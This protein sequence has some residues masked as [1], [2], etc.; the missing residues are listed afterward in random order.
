MYSTKNSQAGLV[1]ILVTMVMMIVIS[2]IVLGFAEISTNEQRNSLDSQLSVQAYYAAESGVDDAQAAIS[3]ILTSG[4]IVPNKTVCGNQPGYTLPGTVNATNNVS[5][6]CVLVN[7]SP[8]SLVY[9]VGFTSTVVPLISNGPSF[10]GISFSWKIPQGVVGNVSSCF[11]N[12]ASLGTFPVASGAGQWTCVYPVVRVDFL[13]ANGVLA[14]AN[15]NADTAT[16]FF[17][18][19]NSLSVNNNT[20]LA[21]RG[22]LVPARCTNSSC[23]ANLSS[24]LGGTKYYA[25]ITTLYRTNSVLTITANGNKPFSNAQAT[26]DATGRAQ[27]VLKRVQVAV[28]LSDAN[29]HKIPTAALI[30]GDSVCKRF[31]VTNNSLNVYND[32]SAGGGGNTL[33]SL[34]AAGTPS[35]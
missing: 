22:T 12:L 23:A 32:M 33:C 28:D 27:D 2:L 29:A 7:A 30:T 13:D 4:A 6:T 26:I 17:V 10:G 3:N 8:T 19:F 31:G 35:P 25:R 16:M 9:N 14:R 18:P 5:Y 11:N 21:D 20:T 34:Q 1:S 24:G 15:W